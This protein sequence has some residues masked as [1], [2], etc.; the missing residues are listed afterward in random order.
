MAFPACSP[1]RRPPCRSSPISAAA[2]PVTRRSQVMTRSRQHCSDSPIDGNTMIRRIAMSSVAYLAC[3]GIAGATV[4]EIGPGDDFRTAMQNLAPGD[5]LVM[6]GG[7]Y[8]LSSYFELDLA[9]TASAPIGIRAAAGEQPVIH[10][11]DS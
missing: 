10:Y 6:H 2:R 5:T 4:I 11:V 9:G 8:A 3:S 1:S 7:T